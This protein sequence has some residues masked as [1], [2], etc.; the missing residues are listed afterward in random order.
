MK[1]IFLKTLREEED[2]SAAIAAIKTLLT[3]IQNYKGNQQKYPSFT[4]ISSLLHVR[5]FNKHML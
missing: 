4:K 5:V 1:E 3:V 2:I